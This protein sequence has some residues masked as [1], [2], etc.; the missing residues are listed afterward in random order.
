MFKNNVFVLTFFEN[1]FKDQITLTK[2]SI[3][4]IWRMFVHEFNF[5]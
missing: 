5:S 2:H 3:K 4:V 1:V